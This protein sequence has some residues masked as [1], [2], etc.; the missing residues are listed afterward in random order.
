MAEKQPQTQDTTI[1][2]KYGNSIAAHITE[3]ALIPQ[4]HTPQ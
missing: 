3:D 2:M 4:V 1:Y